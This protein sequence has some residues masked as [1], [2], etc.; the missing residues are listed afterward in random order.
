MFLGHLFWLVAG[1]C[2]GGVPTVFHRHLYLS[3]STPVT[4]DTLGDLLNKPCSQEACFRFPRCMSSS[5]FVCLRLFSRAWISFTQCVA[6][7]QLVVFRW[8][9]SD[10]E[11][12]VYLGDS[13]VFVCLFVCLFFVRLPATLVLPN[14]LF[15]QQQ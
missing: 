5:P 14:P 4:F 10:D 12:Y 3:F 15:I 2:Q 11:K 13:F 6:C 1:G 9:K 8:I 7:A